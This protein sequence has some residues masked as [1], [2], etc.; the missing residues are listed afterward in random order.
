[1]FSSVFSPNSSSRRSYIHTYSVYRIVLFCFARAPMRTMAAASEGGTAMELYPRLAVAAAPHGE[2]VLRAAQKDERRLN[3]LATGASEGADKALHARD[4]T[5]NN[6]DAAA[7]SAL[8]SRMQGGFD[9]D[10]TPPATQCFAEDDESQLPIEPETRPPRLI[11][12]R[13][14]GNTDVPGEICLPA[15]GPLAIGRNKEKPEGGKALVLFD[16]NLD[17]PAVSLNHAR[18]TRGADGALLLQVARNPA[19]HNSLCGSQ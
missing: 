7:H 19:Y 1:M 2:Q 13:D 4:D 17:V 14:G 6:D 18:I 15:D 12:L 16:P 11:H 3:E 5:E 8:L 9:G 10:G